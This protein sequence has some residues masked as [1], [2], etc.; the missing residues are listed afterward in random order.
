MKEH[1]INSL[2]NFIGAWTP[3]DINICDKLIA[4]HRNSPAK[5]A[6]KNHKGV[7][8]SAKD[9]TDCID[10]DEMAY[11]YFKWLTK[12][13]NKYVEK[14]PWSNKYSRFRIKEYIYIQHY[15]PNQGYHA[16]HT[17]RAMAEIPNAQRH[18]V[19]MTYLNDVTEGGETEFFHQNLRI[20]PEKGLTVIWPADWTFTHRGIPSTT[21]EKYIITGWFSYVPQKNEESKSP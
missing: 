12:V 1:V 13:L 17:E 3:D 4:F 10:D 16:W 19:F 9:S 7:V 21:Q 18:L 8:P 14:Y 2:D 11:E 15:A 6:G 20:K 5:F